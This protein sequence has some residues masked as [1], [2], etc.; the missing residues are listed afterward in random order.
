[1]AYVVRLTA[2]NKPIGPAPFM[3]EAAAPNSRAAILERRAAGVLTWSGPA[4]ML[5]A[6]SAFAV[7]AQG[8]VAISMS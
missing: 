4:L 5:F 2:F 6:R 1:M 3:S 8:L 7:A